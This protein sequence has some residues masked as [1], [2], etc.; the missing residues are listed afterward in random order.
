MSVSGEFQRKGIGSTILKVLVKR[1]ARDG[2][3]EVVLETTASW[4][5]AVAFYERNGFVARVEQDGDQY[6]RIAL[7]QT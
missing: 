7:A 6:F 5:S 1:A 4:A 2:Y 3:R